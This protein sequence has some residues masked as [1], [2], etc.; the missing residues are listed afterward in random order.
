MLQLQHLERPVPPLDVVA[1]QERDARRP[2]ALA[3]GWERFQSNA[4]FVG[5]SLKTVVSDIGRV[6]FTGKKI[7]ARPGVIPAP[8][9]KGPETILEKIQ[10][11]E[12]DNKRQAD[13]EHFLS[14]RPKSVQAYVRAVRRYRRQLRAYNANMAAQKQKLR[15]KQ[16]RY[17]A[18]L[19]RYQDVQAFWA[20]TI[21]HTIRTAVVGSVSVESPFIA[22]S[23]SC[24]ADA[25]VRALTMFDRYELLGTSDPIDAIRVG[26][27]ASSVLFTE[28]NI[29][30]F[31]G[32]N[33]WQSTVAKSSTFKYY[34]SAPQLQRSVTFLPY[35]DLGL[36]YP[37]TACFR[38]H[39][40]RS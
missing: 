14:T 7:K 4:R 9:T 23:T 13:R 11:E 25:W 3:S 28:Q 22:D 24:T 1:R 17:V 6:F 15:S 19:R 40:G 36:P 12:A 16:R 5:T 21:P 32:Y 35:T 29:A 37:E 10:R 31:V 34:H 20:H 26:E 30:R 27:A 18:A 8:V 38:L 33:L 39:R 2:A